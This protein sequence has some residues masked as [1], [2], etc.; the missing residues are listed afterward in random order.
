[1]IAYVYTPSYPLPGDLILLT[2][3]ISGVFEDVRLKVDLNNGDWIDVGDVVGEVNVIIP[4]RFEEPGVMS[5]PVVMEYE[6]NGRLMLTYHDVR[7]PVYP[8][9]PDVEVRGRLKE[10]MKNALFVSINAPDV[11]SRLLIYVPGSEEGKKEFVNVKT[12][13]TP[14]TLVPDCED[15]RGVNVYVKGIW[16]YG[17]YEYNNT[18][19]ILC[20]PY[21]P[22]VYVEWGE[23]NVIIHVSNPSDVERVFS[24]TI[25]TRGLSMYGDTQGTMRV[26]PRSQE[27]I[28]LHYIVT[29]RPELTLLLF[30]DR[31]YAFTFTPPPLEPAIEARAYREGD[32]ISVV[33][34]NRGK[35][36]AYNVRVVTE[37]DMSYIGLLE[38]GDYDTASVRGENVRI[39]YEWEGGEEVLDIELPPPP[40]NTPY[41]LLVLLIPVAWWVWKR[42]SS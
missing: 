25:K 32:S 24:Y 26:P 42:I 5:V 37:S 34:A 35:G 40:D 1:M 36:V 9:I 12:V 16:K 15:Y 10:G 13:E 29:G 2:L 11:F 38:P 31:N 22:Y 18:F 27:E 3:V 8:G 14:F 21:T 23:E 19:S 20:E 41:W 39:V 7:I 17:V 4:L 33:V 30:G 28:M 6:V